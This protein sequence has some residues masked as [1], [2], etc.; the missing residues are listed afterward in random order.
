MRTDSF[1]LY[2]LS[3]YESIIDKI[4]EDIR[5]HDNY[6]DVKLILTEALTN[7]FNHGNKKDDEKPI[8]LRY[9]YECQDRY[10]KFEIEDSGDIARNIVMSR[11]LSDDNILNNS[12]RGL[13]LINCIADEVY[14]QENTI[15]IQKN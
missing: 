3:K 15:V 2:G 7:A 10:V 11:E 4:I 1:V 5:C 12:G 13:F 8:Y 9:E 6:F 14:F